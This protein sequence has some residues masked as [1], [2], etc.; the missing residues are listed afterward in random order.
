MNDDSEQSALGERL[1][2]QEAALAA[3]RQDLEA[4]TAKLCHDLKAPLR[5]M[6][7]FS[8]ALTED[9]ADAL[10]D[11]GREYL[12]YIADGA[13]SMNRMIGDLQT[14]NRIGTGTLTFTLE[15]L[16]DVVAAVA[17]RLAPEIS[18]SG[19]HI[20]IDKPLEDVQINRAS[21]EQALQHIVDNALRFA[22]PGTQPHIHIGAERVPEGIMLR[23]T[24]N[25]IGI[26]PEHCERIFEVFLRLNPGRDTESTGIG[27]A[28]VRKVMTLHGGTVTASPVPGGG[29]TI[30]M[31]IP[32][33]PRD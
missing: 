18:A 31:F 2:R 21:F 29:T 33:M 16:E 15:S 25:G 6:C 7:V 3:A 22:Q 24:D 20:D 14:Y 26:A 5:A 1:Q 17:S 27:L 23:V 9:Y 32:A 12:G 19:A 10:D 11:T 4:F 28:I 30:E 13:Q 8:E